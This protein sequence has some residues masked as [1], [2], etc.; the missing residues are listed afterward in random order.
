MKLKEFKAWIH[1]LIEGLEA[2][3][4][5]EVVSVL[6][7]V[8]EKLETVEQ[9]QFADIPL[10]PRVDPIPFDPDIVRPRTGDWPH[11]QPVVVMYGCTPTEWKPL[12]W[13]QITYTTSYLKTDAP[14]K[15]DTNKQ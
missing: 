1:G 9:D 13:D 10:G 14:E 4:Q 2:N 7:K 15:K 8:Q 3:K 5:D 6:K 12:P 11:N